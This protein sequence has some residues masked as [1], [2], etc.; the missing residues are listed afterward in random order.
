MK[1]LISGSTGLVGSRIVE[2]LNKDFE[3]IPLLQSAI[4]IT[5][6]D[7]V[8]AFLEKAEFDLFLHL[9]AY[10]NV[11]GAESEREKAYEINV[12]GT[13]N[14][15]EETKKRGKEFIYISTDFV[16][17]GKTP[18]Y[19]EES[20]PNPLGYYAQTKYEGEQIVGE[21]AMIVR[22]GFPYRAA[23]ERPDF[24]R[25]LKD[26]LEK[27]QEIKVVSDSQFTPTFIDDIA[28]ALGHLLNNYSPEIFHIVGENSLSPF[29]AVEEIARVFG[30]D[31][32]LIKQTT[33]EE[34]Y[35]GKAPRPKLTVIKSRK[36]NFYQMKNFSEG[37]AEIKKQ[38]S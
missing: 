10:T 7:Q 12:T 14:V 11:D 29:D 28:Y 21:D 8:T 37:L 2:L 17:D 22:L 38:L 33:F 18:P 1:V 23:S 20:K 5:E 27:R 15:F 31:T 4:D 32:N 24:A 19:F 34:F 13:K 36:N 3:F 35:K 25:N 16:F 30:L 6:K 9:A 26:L